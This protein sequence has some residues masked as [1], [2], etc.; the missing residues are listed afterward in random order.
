M[1][2]IHGNKLSHLILYAAQQHA[3]APHFG[4]V[5]L[6]KVLFWSDFEHF[7]KTGQSITGHAYVKLPNGP[8]PER[9]DAE[10]NRMQQQGEL[11]MVPEQIGPHTQQRPV[12]LAEPDMSVFSEAELEIIDR[13]ISQHQAMTASEASAYSHV[14][15]GWQAARPGERIP[16]GT[17]WIVDPPPEP[18]EQDQ[19]IA[20]QIAAKLGRL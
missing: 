3:V 6:A 18:T 15:V 11:V 16:F 19:E 12:A 5:L 17:A 10:L 8:V 13:V 7:A 1:P 14:T 4:K 9:F 2:T 20:R